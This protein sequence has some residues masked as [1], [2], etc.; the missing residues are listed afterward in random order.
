MGGSAKS[1]PVHSQ[2]V[3]DLAHV[4]HNRVAD[5][6]GLTGLR[7][8]F[9]LA[10]IQPVHIGAAGLALTIVGIRLV[11]ACAEVI[12]VAGVLDLDALVLHLIVAP[13]GTVRFAHGVH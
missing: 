1:L 11:H 7:I 9:H 5:H 8:H 3:A 4:R 13:E 6:R 10:Q 12:G 2:F